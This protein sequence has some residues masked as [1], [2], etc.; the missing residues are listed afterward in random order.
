RFSTDQDEFLKKEYEQYLENK[1]ETYVSFLKRV[2]GKLGIEGRV[3]SY[4]LT[5]LVGHIEKLRRDDVSS[6]GPRRTAYSPETEETPEVDF[7]ASPEAEEALKFL[8]ESNENIFLT[9]E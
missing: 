2:S 8:E 7:S 5:Q 3:V 4:R 6:Y 1:R 9:G